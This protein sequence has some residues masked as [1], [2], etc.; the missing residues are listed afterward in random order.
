MKTGPYKI[1]KWQLLLWL[2]V[3]LLMAALLTLKLR[4]VIEAD[5][6][7]R[8]AL[9]VFTIGTGVWGLGMLVIQFMQ[10][11]RRMTC[12]RA[13]GSRWAITVPFED[14]KTT[15]E[16]RVKKFAKQCITTGVL[17]QV[18]SMLNTKLKSI[19]NIP[20]VWVTIRQERICISESRKL[21]AKGKSQNNYCEIEWHSS[22]S[23]NYA[24]IKHELAHTILT[25]CAPQIPA[26]EHHKVMLDSGIK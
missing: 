14:I 23:T 9:Y 18:Y 1:F 8:I 16:L 25:Y 15:E 20:F 19:S 3:P 7:A 4:G 22:L 6:D 11:F 17:N 26:G 24:L 12:I 10:R 5:G 13:Q 21:Y 2:L